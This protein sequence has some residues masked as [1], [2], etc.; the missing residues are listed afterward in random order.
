MRSDGLDLTVIAVV[1]PDASQGYASSIYYWGTDGNLNLGLT[2]EWPVNQFGL[3]WP[4]ADGN[5]RRS[6]YL[7][8]LAGRVQVLRFVNEKKLCARDTRSRWGRSS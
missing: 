7:N 6:P 3:K 4:D 5:L 8:A 1:K 2:G